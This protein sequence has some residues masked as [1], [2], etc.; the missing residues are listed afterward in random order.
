MSH[1]LIPSLLDHIV[2]A[3]PDLE[4]TVEEFAQATGVRPEKGGSHENLG[5]RNYLVTFGGGHYLEFVGVDENIPHPQGDYPFNLDHLDAAGVSTWAIHPEDP[6]AAVAHAEAAGVAVGK[7]DALSRRTPDGTL[8][9]WRL[10]PSS[11]G[12]LPFIIDWQDSVS[13]AFSTKATAELQ[14]FYLAT[15]DGSSI[16]SQLAALGT[17]IDVQH[18]SDECCPGSSCS[19]C[20]RVEIA[21]P[22]GVWTI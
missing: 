21:G 18:S 9:T 14:R 6:D 12:P 1:K 5:T 20:L 19:S 11:A 17:E 2:V 15:N 10:T 16:Q 22:A 7:L 8:L 3:T 4:A 13:P